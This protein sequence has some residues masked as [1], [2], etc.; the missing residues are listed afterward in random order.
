M[1]EPYLGLGASGGVRF[2]QRSVVELNA[3]VS[4]YVVLF[5]KFEPPNN[6]DAPSLESYTI[7]WP[8]LGNGAGEDDLGVQLKVDVLY[9]QVSPITPL[10][11]FPPKRIIKR[12]DSS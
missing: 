9:A 2:V 12:L 10:A 5:D 6:S 1:Q 4:P 8:Y 7:V 11:V 3:H